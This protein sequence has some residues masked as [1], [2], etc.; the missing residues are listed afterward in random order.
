MVYTKEEDFTKKESGLRICC[1]RII[2]DEAYP[3]HAMAHQARVVAALHGTGLK[4]PREL[5]ADIDPRKTIPAERMA[6]INA[7][8]WPTG[9]ELKCRFIGGSKAQQ[10]KAIKMANIW[11]K[12]ANIKIKFVKTKNEQV[13]I[14]FMEGQGSWSAVGSDALDEEYFPKNEAT[15]N[16]GWLDLAT[17][18]EEW[19]RVVVHEFGHALGCI[20]EHQ[21]PKEHLKWDKKA[22][23]K[24]FSGPPN[25]WSKDEIDWNILKKYS[26]KGV[27]ATIFDKDSI[28]LYMF[29]AEL[30]TDHKGTPENTD[31][32]EKDIAFIKQMYPGK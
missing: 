5:F 18:D 28:M 27:S 23:Y 20:H 31:L 9:S 22:V 2:P 30:F 1:D 21:S 8:K 26:A 19:R 15:M 7:K 11:M 13:R 12:Y 10:E 14:D 29:P 25:S 3:A 6:V 16:F 32:S 24:Y 4:I 17:P